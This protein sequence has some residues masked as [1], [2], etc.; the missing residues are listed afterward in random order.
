MKNLIEKMN[1]VVKNLP[2]SG[3][4]MGDL[5]ILTVGET[6][7]KHDTREY[8]SGRGT[9]YNSSIRHG[10]ISINMTERELNRAYKPIAERIK[11]QKAYDNFYKNYLKHANDESFIR[12]ELEKRIDIISEKPAP[13]G[14]ERYY[15][16]GYHGCGVY[17]LIILNGKIAAT[18]YRGI[19]NSCPNGTDQVI[20]GKSI[21]NYITEKLGPSMKNELKATEENYSPE[22]R[23]WVIV[24]ADGSG[25]Q[26]FLRDEEDKIFLNVKE[27]NVPAPN[28]DGNLGYVHRNIQI[29]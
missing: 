7:V 2:G 16:N 25:C 13:E 10:H 18:I 15:I 8:Y 27:Y 17:R 14:D 11:K 21:M 22:F 19:H 12:S 3:Y 4:K 28:G 26:F 29:A 6:T 24:K 9:K 5:F 20:W 23:N 1:Q